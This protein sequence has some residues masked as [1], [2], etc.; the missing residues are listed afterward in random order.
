MGKANGTL[1]E[2]GTFVLGVIERLDIG[3]FEIGESGE[4]D[5]TAIELK[6]AAASVLAAGEARAL[7]ALQL[8]SNQVLARISEDGG[9]VVLDV[10]GVSDAR[11]EHLE[12]LAN[13]VVKRARDGGRAIALDPMNARD[14]RVVHLAVRDCDGVATMSV[15]E[16]RYR[17][18]VVVP[19]GADEYEEALRQSDGG[20][21][22][23]E[24]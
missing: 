20:D 24:H 9:R 4:G 12:R 3:P 6:G 18:V 15:G 2:I 19:E 10:E 8:I 7:D 23:R 13:R 14:R 5:V 1:G 17:Q 11:E 22:P 16:G 21:R